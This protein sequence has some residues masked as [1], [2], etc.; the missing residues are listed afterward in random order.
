M[1]YRIELTHEAIAELKALTSTVQ[2]R[3]LRKVKW[4]AENFDAVSH[5]R[6]SGN[7]SKLYKL[8]IGDYRVIYSF[9]TEA[10]YITIHKIG[11]RREIYE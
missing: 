4:M 1:N 6:L 5:Q 9:D 8:R 3:V 11:H 2:E 10:Q 7:L